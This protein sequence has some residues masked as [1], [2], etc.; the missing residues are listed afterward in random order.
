AAGRPAGYRQSGDHAVPGERAGAADRSGGGC[1]QRRYH[2]AAPRQPYAQIGQRQCRRGIV[3]GPLQRARNDGSDRV[4]AGCPLA[5]CHD[6][7][8]LPAGAGR[9]DGS[10]AAGCVL[11]DELQRGNPLILIADDDQ[12]ER[13]LQRQVLE[14]AGFDIVEAKSGTA[15]LE[16]YAEC[17]PDLVLLDVMMPEMNGFDVCR[18]IRTL[19]GGRNTPVLMATSLDDVDSIEEAYRVG[20]TDFIDK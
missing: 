20:A 4:G 19:P 15:A 5:G 7:R 1:D 3:V 18:A 14:S 17:K 12:T 8:G 10:S 2:A 16:L 9:S 6:R 11:A 13:F